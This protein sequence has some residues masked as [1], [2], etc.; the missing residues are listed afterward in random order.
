MKIG[1]DFDNT[2]V[3]YD[4]VFHAAALDRGLI[5]A[6]V[7]T[8]KNAVRDHLNGSGRNN[9]FTELQGYVYG[10]RMDLAK[11]YTGVKEF[12]AKAFKAG[13]ALYI[14]SH[15]TRHPIAGPQY[16]MHEAARGFLINAGLMG[17]SD[18]MIPPN[19]T[20]FEMT[21]EEKMARAGA[22]GVDVFID[23]LPEI[24]DMPGLKSEATKILFD[25]LSRHTP[26]T[27]VEAVA[28][29]HDITALLLDGRAH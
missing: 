27:D 22:L 14:V 15:K 25:P 20:F 13:H 23:D 5:D 16:D 6:S 1:I 24:L 4:G 28:S 26:A 10:A 29:W 7:G 2:I 11:T 3:N 17:E 19:Q 21:K 18:G 9:E 12:V 8:D